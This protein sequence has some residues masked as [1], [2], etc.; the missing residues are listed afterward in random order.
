MHYN[1]YD[2]Y[3]NYSTSITSLPSHN[4]TVTTGLNHKYSVMLE[5]YVE[6]KVDIMNEIMKLDK[7]S[8][9]DFEALTLK[10]VYDRLIK[11]KP[12]LIEY[13]PQTPNRC[14]IALKNAWNKKTKDKIK[15]P[16]T[17]EFHRQYLK[18]KLSLGPLE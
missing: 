14:L 16:I 1:P 6:E 15:I 5:D 10:E 12:Y 13:V 2:P 17:G 3:H 7:D 11:S 18:L 8:D 4:H 9:E